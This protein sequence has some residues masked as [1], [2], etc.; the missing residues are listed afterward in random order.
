MPQGARVKLSPH[1]HHTLVNEMHRIHTGILAEVPGQALYSW[2]QEETEKPMAMKK[3]REEL[4]TGR[5]AR[6]R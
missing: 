4:D 2:G 3:A 1:C 5:T 6:R